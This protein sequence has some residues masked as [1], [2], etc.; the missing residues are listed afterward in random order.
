MTDTELELMRLKMSVSILERAVIKIHLLAGMATGITFDESVTATLHAFELS[1][2]A[3]RGIFAPINFDSTQVAL[4]EA[5][6]SEN[7]ERLRSYIS[8]IKKEMGR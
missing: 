6:L 3:L 1:D 7:Y 4:L 5:E 8:D 2:E